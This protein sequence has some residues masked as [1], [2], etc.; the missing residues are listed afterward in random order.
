MNKHGLMTSSI[1]MPH[2]FSALHKVLVAGDTAQLE[3]LSKPDQSFVIS[4]LNGLVTY[5]MCTDQRPLMFE[6]PLAL[7]ACS[8]NPEMLLAILGVTRDVAKQDQS[9]NNIV[10]SLV[11]LAD[12]HPSTACKMYHTLM[13]HANAEKKLKLLET[14]NQN[15]LTPLSLAAEMCV[16]EIVNCILNTDGVYK[17]DM[18][19]VGPYK[20]VMYKFP[21]Q[22][23]LVDLMR[24]L[25]NVPNSKLQRF[26]DTDIL[27]IPPL[28]VF[29]R[30]F[31]LKHL[32]T[33]MLWTVYTIL[34]F[35]GYFV[36]MREYLATGAPP[37]PFFTA[38]LA[39]AM[40]IYLMEVVSRMWWN[41]RNYI[42]FFRKYFFGE[43][44][45][46]LTS[47][48]RLLQVPT[49]LLCFIITLTDTANPPCEEYKQLRHTFHTL[50]N[51][52]MVMSLI[53]LLQVYSKTAYLLTVIQKMVL[54]TVIF[55][56]VGFIP[57]LAFA[58]VFLIL[59]APFT[60]LYSTVSYNATMS[61]SGPTLNRQDIPEY[62]YITLMRLLNVQPPD[63]VLF[64]HSIVPSLSMAL[65]VIAVLMWPLLLL[66]LLIALYNDKMQEIH[67]HKEV[68]M[69][70]QNFNVM[71]FVYD[72]YYIPFAKL[73]HV[74]RNNTLTL[75]VFPEIIYVMQETV[76]DT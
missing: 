69:A 43:R 56:F 53:Y 21:T 64:R 31:H 63:D 36:Y 70:V 55:I 59:E 30:R 66:N 54:E 37:Q 2:P 52:T 19:T 7:G 68:I 57:Y 14:K 58:F 41:R 32:W 1:I 6:L 44:P 11:V 3:E 33:F 23:M 20:Q 5:T 62:M 60:C 71:L 48:T 28:S 61:I 12:K 13:A 25:S 16:P 74:L 73:K 26:T 8:G 51:F 72:S 10:H 65:Y 34:I 50:I 39:L 18:D 27:N 29:R 17:F 75:S 76:Q 35:S 4:A 15:L 40:F 45:F 24:R 38:L 46:I 42:D 22:D 67:K 47:G 49:A 9:G